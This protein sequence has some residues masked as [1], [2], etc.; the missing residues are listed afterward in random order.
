[1]RALDDIYRKVKSL[2]KEVT[3]CGEMAGTPP[4]ALALLSLGYDQLSILPS[5]TPVIRHLCRQAD[6]GYLGGVRNKILSEKNGRE[7]ESCLN[8]ALESLDPILVEIE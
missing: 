5:R 4:G 6:E 7:I 2:G 8:E 3:V 1:M